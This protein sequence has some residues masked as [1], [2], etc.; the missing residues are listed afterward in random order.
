MLFNSYPFILI[1][2]PV[3]IFGFFLIARQNNR[4]AVVWLAATSVFFYG[5]WNLRYLFLLLSSII[6]NFLAGRLISRSAYSPRTKAYLAV[7][8][9]SNLL[10]LGYFKYANFFIETANHF[11]ARVNLMNIVL[12]LGISFFTF[13]QVAFLVDAYRGISKEYNFMDYLLFVTW[14]PHLIAG[15]VLHHKQMMPQ[16]GS[17]ATFRPQ[18]ESISVGLTLFTIGLC[19]KVILA[20]QFALYADPVF[21][22]AAQ[23]QGPKLFEAWIGALA[24]ALQLY[25][26]FSAYS[27]MAIGLSRIFN[28]KLPLNFNSPYKAPS[29]IEFWRRWHITLSVFLRDYLYIPLGGNRNG[30]LWRQ[31]NILITM[32]LGGLWHGANWNFLLWGGLHG[33]YLVLNHGWRSLASGMAFATSNVFGCVARVITFIAVVI[34]WIPFRAPNLESAWLMWK[35]MIGGNGVSLPFVLQNHTE[36]FLGRVAEYSS[37]MGPLLGNATGEILFCLAG[38]IV[39]IW[40]L[41]NSQEWLAR[42][43]PAWNHVQTT[44]G[45]AWRPTGRY[46]IVMGALFGISL[47]LMSRATPFLYYHF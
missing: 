33:M 40:A 37:G 8:I 11:G 46:A 5:W 21:D 42:Y 16:F 32:L 43:Q 24:Y 45:L 22:G 35:G 34:A 14:F 38:G 39:I 1:Y 4:L 44:T 36:R 29:I 7:A 9:A 31:V 26:D 2:L 19:K 6:F 15:P 30:P 25:F 3:T 13:T 23:G 10:L 17:P 47:L 20:D 28:F 12:P 41:P 27:D 18:A